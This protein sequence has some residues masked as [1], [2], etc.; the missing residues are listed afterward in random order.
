MPRAMGAV[1]KFDVC[2]LFFLRGR[3]LYRP[4]RAPRDHHGTATA[5][6]RVGPRQ[7]ETHRDKPDARTTPHHTCHLTNDQH[8]LSERPRPLTAP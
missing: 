2:S 7:T 1:R 5:R 6:P 4:P 3:V 8:Q